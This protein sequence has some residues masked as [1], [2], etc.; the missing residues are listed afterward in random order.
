MARPV[1]DAPATVAVMAELVRPPRQAE[2]EPS[3]LSKMN[4]D[5]VPVTSKSV[6]AVVT[7]G[8]AVLT[9]PVGPLESLGGAA[10]SFATPSVSSVAELEVLVIL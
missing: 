6:A 2:I 10:P 3:R 8:V 1:K 9:W 7:P 4:D 5:L